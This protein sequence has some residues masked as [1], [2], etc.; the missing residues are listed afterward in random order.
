MSVR[1]I[2]PGLWHW[3]AVHPHIRSRVSSYYQSEPGVLI[4]PLA[5]EEGVEWF[6]DHG[7]PT[8]I[9]LSNRH[10]FRD[11]AKF[12][13]AFSIPVRASRPGMHE[14][15]PGQDVVPFDFGD[16]L[17]GDVVAHEVGAICP[18]ETALEIP[19]S[20]ALSVADG[21][22]R[23]DQV[24]PL[25]FVPD[26]LLGDDPEDVKRGLCA[27]YTRLLDLDFDHL[28]LAHGEP[29]LGNGKAKLREF[30]QLPSV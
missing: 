10:H 28:L 3:T 2:V 17:P 22:V 18:D 14:F 6:A 7:P 20:R 5:P 12:V 21:V 4:D 27:A 16:T 13:E 29:I 24:G 19:A 30:V 23:L 25:G 1:E 8:A 11:C 26:F 9:L 15:G